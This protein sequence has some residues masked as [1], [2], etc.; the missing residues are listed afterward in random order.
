[1]NV[2]RHPRL[3]LGKWVLFRGYFSRVPEASL[4]ALALDPEPDFSE[5]RDEVR[6]ARITDSRETSWRVV[7]GPSAK[8]VLLYRTSPEEGETLVQAVDCSPFVLFQRNRVTHV[9]LLEGDCVWV[10]SREF[11][12][13]LALRHPDRMA[14]KLATFP[15]K[16]F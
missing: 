8:S 12:L 11:Q 14:V 3:Y 2:K 16:L 9:L 13:L 6:E 5:A 15:L 10:R 1:M 7:V 4:E